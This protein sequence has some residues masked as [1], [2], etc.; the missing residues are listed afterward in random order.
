MSYDPILG[1]ANIV[2]DT[3]PQ[4]GG[5]LDTQTFTVDG[6]D[7]GTDGTKLD[8]VESGADVTDATN[9]DAAGATMNADTDVSSNSYVVDEDDMSSDSATKL[10]TQ[11]SIKAYVDA[12]DAAPATRPYL[13]TNYYTRNGSITI[14]PF[15]T[16]SDTTAQMY[17]LRVVYNAGA[18]VVIVKFYQNQLPEWVDVSEDITVYLPVQL[19]NATPTSGEGCY[20]Q[21][22][23]DYFDPAGV[24]GVISEYTATAKFNDLNAMGWTHTH[25]DMLNIGTIAGGTLPSEAV[26]GIAWTAPINDNSKWTMSNTKYLNQANMLQLEC[27]PL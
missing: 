21:V 2:E 24:A 16:N 18:S 10:A 15:I 14:T 20:H 9:V 26:F 25:T 7:V 12:G 5:N 27:V 17:G 19:I 8:S 22:F 6:R 4:L 11:Q 1:I 13:V 23:V 3:T